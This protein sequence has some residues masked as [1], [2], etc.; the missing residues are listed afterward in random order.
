M[1]RLISTADTAKL[2]RS[3][4][5]AAFP[6][7]SFQVRSK[8]YAGGSSIDV[9]WT[10]GPTQGQVLAV[11][12]PFEGATFDAMQDLKESRIVEVNGEKIRYGADY[13]FAKRAYSEAVRIAVMTEVAARFGMEPLPLE[14]NGWAWRSGDGGWLLRRCREMIEA[15]DFRESAPAVVADVQPEPMIEATN[16]WVCQWCGCADAERASVLQA[17]FC[18]DCTDAMLKNI[19]ETRRDL[20]R[21]PAVVVDVQ[22][23]PMTEA[24]NHPQSVDASAPT[25]PEPVE[26]AP[27]NWY[28]EKQALRR[29]RLTARAVKAQNEAD[30]RFGKARSEVAQIPFGQ[31]IL[32]GHHSERKHRAALNRHDRAI[33]KGIEAMDYA[34]KLAAQAAAVGAGGISS[35]DPEALVKLQAELDRAVK[36]QELMIAANKLI[37]KNDRVG[38][39]ALGLS[40]A[41]IDQLFTPDFAK[42]IGFPGYA[43]KNNNASI[44]RIK[45]RITSIQSNRAAEEAFTPIS[46]EGWRIYAEDN[47]ICIAFGERQSAERVQVIKKR[48][49]V[50]SPTRNAWVRKFS[51]NAVYDAKQLIGRFK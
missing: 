29:E 17:A 50:W 37:K 47:R 10:D 43:L 25:E 1:I 5:K 32:I 20:Y 11:T 38:L 26:P 36:N 35:D 14:G 27:M 44:R 28:E 4:L 3:A 46:G 48:G 18:F 6:G 39:A 41:Q 13:V 15:R 33:R 30:T 34:E 16:K 42:R 19:A 24:V 45:E 7:T 21:K 49:F 9:H 22:P 8:S 2:I 12:N 23:E 40:E 31:P 51:P